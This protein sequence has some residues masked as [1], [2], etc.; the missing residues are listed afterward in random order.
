[1]VVV[2]VRGGGGEERRRRGGGKE[3][4]RRRRGGGG[5]EATDIK[6]NN[7]GRPK[8]RLRPLQK[9]WSKAPVEAEAGRKVVVP[10]AVGPHR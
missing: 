1:M 10:M 3:E 6:S 2:A 8:G 4:E 9:A 7:P 5:E